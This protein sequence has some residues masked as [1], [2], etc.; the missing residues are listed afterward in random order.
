MSAPQFSSAPRSQIRSFLRPPPRKQAG[1]TASAG[2]DIPASGEVDASGFYRVEE[3]ID[4]IIGPIGKFTPSPEEMPNHPSVGF[5][6]KRRTGKSYAARDLCHKC[7]QDIPFG[8]VL[9]D[10]KQ[11]GFWQQYFPEKF[12]FQGLRMDVLKNL[13]ARQKKLVQKFGKDD[14][15]IR[16]IVIL[17]RQCYY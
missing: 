4:S 10:T 1:E 9:T 6:G 11:N 13:M 3:P 12:V 15:R 16:C 14:P 7:F 2:I 8:V 5:F 17:G